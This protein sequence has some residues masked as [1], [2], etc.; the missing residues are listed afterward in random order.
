[1][2]GEASTSQ[3]MDY[4]MK[5]VNCS[6][7]TDKIYIWT[8]MINL[9]DYHKLSENHCNLIW[10]DIQYYHKPNNNKLNQQCFP[11]LVFYYANCERFK[12]IIDVLYWLDDEYNADTLHRQITM[13][14]LSCINKLQCLEITRYIQYT[15]EY[16]PIYNTSI[17]FDA[18]STDINTARDLFGGI[19]DTQTDTYNAILDENY[20]NDG[21]NLHNEMKCNNIHVYHVT[22]L[23]LI[24]TFGNESNGL[25]E[26]NDEIRNN[27]YD[28]NINI[29]NA[30]IDEYCIQFL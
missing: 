8:T 3:R 16:I 21:M 11:S 27:R 4:I 14:K 17:S 12:H 13:M 15:I 20:V 7:E 10:K 6:L 18:K 1:M 29:A 30:F 22:Y 28:K 23:Y 2:Y 5:T 19:S 24:K 9:C 25:I 26:I